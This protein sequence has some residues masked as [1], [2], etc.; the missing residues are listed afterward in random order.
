MSSHRKGEPWTE[1]QITDEL[2]EIT[3]KFGKFPST[4]DLKRMRRVDLES[5]IYHSDWDLNYFRRKLGLPEF[6]IKQWTEEEI[7][8]I[9]KKVV[10][11][12]GRFPGQKEL[13]KMN[14]P[15]LMS[16]MRR[17]GSIGDW[18]RKLGLE[19]RFK[20]QG[21][22]QDWENIK[23]E[24][25]P[26]IINGKFPNSNMISNYSIQ[27]GVSICGFGGI[28]KVAQRMGYDPPCYLITTDG[29]YVNSSYEYLVDEFLYSR[30]IPHDVNGVIDKNASRRYRY[31][32]KVEDFFVE[33]W[34][35]HEE[36]L[37]YNKINAAYKKTRLKKEEFYR[38]NNFKLISIESDVFKNKLDIVEETL[39]KIFQN[40]GFDVSLKE[41]T[42]SIHNSYKH[43]H[44]WS[45]EK[46]I[47]ELHEYLKNNTNFPTRNQLKKV[48][49]GLIGAID[50]HG[51]FP[52]FREKM[53]FKI[54]KHREGFWTQDEVAKQLKEVI[55]KLGYFPTAKELIK[56]KRGDLVFGINHTG[57]IV[58]YKKILGYDSWT[59]EEIINKFRDIADKIDGNPTYIKVRELDRSLADVILRRKIGFRNMLAKI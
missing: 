17:I 46:I 53:N 1:E 37:H 56:I 12:T 14:M 30:G 39:S 51:G 49:P 42:F 59:E 18:E 45:E 23:K 9:L 28:N 10:E 22:W 40:H 57:G 24:L 19:P 7:I 38:I 5:A 4:L 54:L 34:G 3:K 55:E 52:Y 13:K 27:L 31:D 16:N 50:R 32:F 44:Y 25:E 15:G 41:A 43:S 11:E 58:Y 21:Y 6:F 8:Q 36:K 47:E 20:P 48:K 29:H 33:V 26:L 2:A 35:L